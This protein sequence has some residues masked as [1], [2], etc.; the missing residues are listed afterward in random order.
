MKTMLFGKLNNML[1][2]PCPASG[3]T[4]D[5]GRDA[6]ETT[7]ISGGRH[8]YR[9]PTTFRRY[10]LSYA[11]STPGLQPLVDCYTGLYGP[12]P[13]YVL[14]FNYTAGNVLPPRWAQGYLLRHIAESWCTPVEVN[15]FSAYSGTASK[16]TNNGAF[17]TQG[18]EQIVPTVP[19]KA[20]YLRAWGSRTGTGVLRVSVLSKATG[21]WTSTD[22]V[23]SATPDDLVVV[24]EA[25][26]VAGTYA[27][28]KLTLMCP[29]ASTLTIDHINLTTDASA[30]RQAGLGVGAVEFTA[31]LSGSIITKAYDRI[32]LKLDIVEVE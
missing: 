26:A 23:P 3:M 22:Y 7:L 6:E 9:A 30:E 17:Y 28:V 12:G 19:D 8:V 32:G 1:S 31:D 4:W 5:I 24:S 20:L 16:F 18:I 11:G 15:S 21:E 13:F 2:V 27:G 14:D 25:D 10:S 29:P